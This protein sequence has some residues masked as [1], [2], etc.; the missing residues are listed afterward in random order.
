MASKTKLYIGCALTDA[1]EDFKKDVEELKSVLKGKD[2]E[3][4]DF[5]GLVAGT[6][7]GVYEWDIDHCIKHCD[8]FIAICDHPGL[9]LGFELGVATE[10]DKPVL[11]LAQ[12]D[13]KISRLIMGAAEAEEKFS[14]IRYKSLGDDAPQLI[15]DWLATF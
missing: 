1:P 3:V 7:K 10:L 5:L 9:G 11:A 15:L 2:Y 13:A 12:K 4:F 6:P 14:F 8:A